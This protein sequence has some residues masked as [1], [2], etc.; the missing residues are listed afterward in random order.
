MISDKVNENGKIG[1][2]NKIKNL[3]LMDLL[4]Q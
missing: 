2:K 3:E 4:K 1:Y